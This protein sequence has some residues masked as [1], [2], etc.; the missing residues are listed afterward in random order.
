MSHQA[1]GSP[2]LAV[3]SELDTTEADRRP[4]GPLLADDPSFGRAQTTMVFYTVVTMLALGFGDWEGTLT[5]V[6][7]EAILITEALCGALAQ[8]FFLG[9]SDPSSCLPSHRNGPV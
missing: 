8:A 3:G 9:Q 5:N 7:F 1:V 6:Y 4:R 2:P